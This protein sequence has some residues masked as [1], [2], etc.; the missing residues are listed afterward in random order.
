MYETPR[1]AVDLSASYKFGKH[2]ELSAGIRDILMQPLTFKQYPEFIDEAGNVCRREQ[3]TKEYR[4][5]RHFS[6][7]LKINL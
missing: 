3:T 7:T 5:G 6:L 1:H 2:V 4:P